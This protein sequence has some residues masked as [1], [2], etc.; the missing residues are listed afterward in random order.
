MI[1]VRRCSPICFTIRIL[2]NRC[3][4]SQILRSKSEE[5]VTAVSSLISWENVAPCSIMK[6]NYKSRKIL[7]QLFHDCY[8]EKTVHK[9]ANIDTFDHKSQKMPSQLF[10]MDIVRKHCT[11]SKNVQLFHN[12]YCE[13][14]LHKIANLRSKSGDA[15][16]TDSR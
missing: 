11:G 5:A 7:S 9:T 3:L 1:K 14:T 16:T 6:F 15:F 2:R 13:K 10:T 12:T 8:C 4:R